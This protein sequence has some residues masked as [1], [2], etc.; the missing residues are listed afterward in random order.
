VDFTPIN[1]EKQVHPLPRI[2]TCVQSSKNFAFSYA[3]I[4]CDR[5][6]IHHDDVYILEN[7]YSLA[8]QCYCG[9]KE[10]VF[11]TKTCI[12]SVTVRIQTHLVPNSQTSQFL[13]VARV[14]G[15]PLQYSFITRQAK[16]HCHIGCTSFGILFTLPTETF[17]NLRFVEHREC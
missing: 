17:C 2:D 11:R 14:M 4:L 12:M 8:T 15:N 16:G 5:E 10:N 6:K 1:Q 13:L 7:T 3:G 9:F